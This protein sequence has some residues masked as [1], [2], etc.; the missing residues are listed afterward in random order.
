MSLEEKYLRPGEVC[1]LL[2]LNAVSLDNLEK[3]GK[4]NCV[5]TKGGRRRFLESDIFSMMNHS[6]QKLPKEKSVT[7]TSLSLSKKKSW[8]DKSLGKSTAFQFPIN[9]NFRLILKLPQRKVKFLIKI[10]LEAIASRSITNP[11]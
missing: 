2:N 8:K 4:V 9:S 5:R 10:F 1:K 11:Q 7:A 6:D 3:D